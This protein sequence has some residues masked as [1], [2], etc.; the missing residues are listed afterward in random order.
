MTNKCD[1]AR[2]LMPLCIDNAASAESSKYVEDHVSQCEE[3]RTYFESMKEVIP[4][5]ET[6][7]EAQEQAAFGQA[8]GVMKKTRRLRVWRNVLTGILIGVLAVFGI[9]AGWQALANNYNRELPTDQYGVSL[10]QLKDG[11]VVVSADYRHSKRKLRADMITIKD[12]MRWPAHLAK[13]PYAYRVWMSTTILP[14]NSEHENRN[15]PIISNVDLDKIDAILLGRSGEQIIW[16][17]GDEIPQ[18]S[19]EMED[20]YQVTRALSNYWDEYHTGITAD[21]PR[22][23]TEE[24][25]DIR[26]ALYEKQEELRL[27]VPEWQ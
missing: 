25:Q 15:G 13:N 1:M 14:I 11:R 21:F 2:D 27:L 7:M 10:A 6:A 3:C 24:E 12:Q 26:A 22:E 19:Q 8:A 16:R 9:L 20:F 17:R 23:E 5:S 18:A 4:K